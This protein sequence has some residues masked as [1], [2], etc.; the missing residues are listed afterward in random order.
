[1]YRFNVSG[2]VTTDR[3]CSWYM[4]I[5][6]CSPLN[7]LI[8]RFLDR[9]VIISRYVLIVSL[10]QSGI[11]VQEEDRLKVADTSRRNIDSSTSVQQTFAR[12]FLQ[13]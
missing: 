12:S 1:M 13:L 8:V 9:F 2:I 6:H 11:K 7:Y 10:L 4:N 5:I 3:K